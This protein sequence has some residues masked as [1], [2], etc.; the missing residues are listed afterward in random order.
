VFSCILP[1]GLTNELTNEGRE[2]GFPA[3]A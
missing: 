2:F 1:V 3:S